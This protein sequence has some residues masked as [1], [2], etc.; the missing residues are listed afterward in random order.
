[1]RQTIL[2]LAKLQLTAKVNSASNV[3]TNTTLNVISSEAFPPLT[4]QCTIVNQL[5]MAEVS[6]LQDVSQQMDLTSSSDKQMQR[7]MVEKDPVNSWA[8]LAGKN[9][10][11]LFHGTA[12]EHVSQ[13]RP[14]FLAYKHVS[15]EAHCLPIAEIASSIARAVDNA[16]QINGIQVMKSG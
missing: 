16:D 6:G 12:A 5:G 14:I 4:A 11:S 9:V 13:V 7:T 10:D 1:M 15:W 8:S 3:E 2:E